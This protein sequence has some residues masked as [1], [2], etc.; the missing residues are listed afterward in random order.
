M[1]LVLLQIDLI[2]LIFLQPNHQ[3][4]Q[5]KAANII[6]NTANFQLPCIENFI[7]EMPAIKDIIVIKLGMN[8]IKGYSLID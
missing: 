5:K 7:D 8:L 4:N 2:F 3:K 6:I 1:S